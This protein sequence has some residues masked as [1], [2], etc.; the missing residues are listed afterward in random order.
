MGLE[1]RT[2]LESLLR[3]LRFPFA[4]EG[5]DGTLSIVS[6][7]FRDTTGLDAGAH[8]PWLASAAQGHEP[9]ELGG[10]VFELAIAP[11]P[12]GRLLSLREVTEA[13]RLEHSLWEQ[14]TR[15]AKIYAEL[16]VRNEALTATIRGLEAGEAK[17]RAVAA[18]ATAAIVVSDRQSRVTFFNAAA[19][20]I[21][22][23]A[24]HEVL[25]GPL[26]RLMPARFAE[27][28][29]AGLARFLATGQAHVIGKTVELV[30][31]RKDGGE[32][33][34]EVSLATW[35]AGEDIF[36]SGIL[37]DI[38]ERKVVE[39]ELLRREAQLREQNRQVEAANRMKSEFLA[40][41]SHELR[42]PL[43]AVIG[44]A[45]LMCDGVVSP[46][47]PEQAEFL[48]YILSSSRHL[49]QLINDVLDLSKVEAGKME[50]RPEPVVVERLVRE[51][52]DIL[53]PLAAPK[54]VPIHTTIDPRLETVTVDPAK[55]KQVL[56]NFLSN[57]LKFTPDGGRVTIRVACEGPEHFRV[58]VEDTGI[59]ILSEELPHLFS[60]FHQ[61]DA[62]AAKKFPGTGLGLALT[63]RIVEAQGGRVGARSIRGQGSIFFA[64]LPRLA[65]VTAPVAPPPPAASSAPQPLP[66]APDAPALSPPPASDESPSRAEGPWV[67]VVEDEP[68]DLS[69]LRR[70][71]LDAGYQVESRTTGA[72]AITLSRQRLFHAVLLD[73]ILPDMAGWDVLRALRA[74]GPNR[75]VPI[76]VVTVV[77]EQTAAAG[78]SI[79]DY[80]VKPIRPQDLLACL[81]RAGVPARDP[82]WV[83]VVEDDP[84]SLR[85]LEVSLKEVGYRPLCCPSGEAALEESARTR[86]AAVILDLLLPGIDGFEFLRRF[87]DLPACRVVPVLVWTSKDLTPSE[88]QKLRA[89]AQAVVLKATGGTSGLLRELAAFVQPPPT[90]G[91]RPSLP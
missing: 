84:G 18:S 48:R 65:V 85:L 38:T 45:Q 39:Q 20:R 55:L 54:D 70:T 10:R 43:N 8:A 82:R 24:A 29:H 58:E 14:Q 27:A 60:E 74:E 59:G 63:R 16:A 68:Q 31:R 7:A 36:F 11:L 23:Y 61:L 78:F 19:E 37:H 35:S 75:E 69:V 3:E 91:A 52:T 87:R 6:Q 88:Q 67:L 34:V 49:L 64:V 17:F 76:I 21:F 13:R 71:L 22:G 81:A 30:G 90:R 44:F 72:E 77:A 80:L 25:G 62:G 4:F 40:N 2:A 53:R 50:F 89:A 56:Y 46:G 83:L 41:M 86:L 5:P 79:Q 9:L 51:V 57:A 47:S 28:H 12:V 15:L 73:L 66:A 1:A 33:P 42:T 32:F 26:T